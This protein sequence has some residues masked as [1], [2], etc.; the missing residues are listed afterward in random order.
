MS[1]TLSL[2]SCI[3]V[4][5]R[6]WMSVHHQVAAVRLREIGVCWNSGVTETMFA[7]VC[8]PVCL[9]ILCVAPATVPAAEHV[10]VLHE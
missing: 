3:A 10:S 7:V 1:L 6:P 2:S 9:L 5:M 8:G 4:H